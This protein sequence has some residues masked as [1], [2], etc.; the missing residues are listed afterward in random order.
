MSELEN[1][2]RQFSGSEEFYR[3]PFGIIYTEGV[4]YLADE[5]KAHWL[6]DAIASW[7]PEIRNLGNRDVL[8]FQVWVLKRTGTAAVLT[9]HADLPGPALVSQDIEYTDFPLD[10]IK[11][12]LE[13]GEHMTLMLPGER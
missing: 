9:M 12:Y 7:Q 13:R 8:D 2:L 1:N 10:E 5:A 4:K 11:L 3:H 6:L